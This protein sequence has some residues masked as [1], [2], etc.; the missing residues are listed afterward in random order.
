MPTTC[1]SKNDRSHGALLPQ[2]RK[3]PRGISARDFLVRAQGIDFDQDHL[4]GVEI[5]ELDS[6][7]DIAVQVLYA[8]VDAVVSEAELFRFLARP[9]RTMREPGFD[10]AFTVPDVATKKVPPRPERLLSPEMEG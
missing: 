4:V 8:H 10:L 7:D 2:D 6:A 5:I 9:E 1:S 3:L